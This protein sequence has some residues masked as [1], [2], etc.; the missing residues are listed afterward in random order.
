MMMAETGSIPNVGGSRMVMPPSGPIPGRTPTIVPRSTPSAQYRRLVGVRQT[1]NPYRR[2]SIAPTRVSKR[3][4][5]GWQGDQE[6][7]AK[8]DIR[9]DAPD[10]R[11][12][13]RR[14]PADLAQHPRRQR[15]KQ[16]HREQKAGALEEPDRGDD[17]RHQINP[18]APVRPGVRRSGGGAQ[19]AHPEEH[20][21]EHAEGQAE[22]ER[23]EPRPGHTEAPE[24][25]LKRFE[26]DPR[27]KEQKN[28][29]DGACLDPLKYAGTHAGDYTTHD[30][31]P[32]P[33]VPCARG[34]RASAASPSPRH[35]AGGARPP[36]RWRSRR[37]PVRSRP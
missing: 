8:H 9:G 17:T 35:R 10:Q 5:S 13:D 37:A 15:Q 25:N 19:E 36:P 2:P 18:V 3:Q 14:Q 30:G 6:H 22:G 12:H 4:D 34:A 31:A 28:P 26:A 20:H 23:E 27:G 32:P 1:E 16:G 24:R 29:G 11:Q 21:G 7:S 33:L